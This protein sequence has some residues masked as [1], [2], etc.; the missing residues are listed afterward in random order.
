MSTHR[1]EVVEVKVLPHPNADA[2]VIVQPFG[3]TVCVRKAEWKDGDLGAYIPPDSVVDSTRPEFAFLAG[4]ERIKVRKLRGIVSQGLLVKAPPGAKIGDDVMEA[5]GVTHY[6]PPVSTNTSGE[7]EAPPPGHRPVYDVENWRRYGHLLV[8]GEDVWVTEKIHG[9]NARFCWAQGRLYAGSRTEWKRPDSTLL[10]WKVAEQHAWLEALCRAQEP[11]TLYGEAYG[12]VQDL[13]YD[14]AP[15]RYSLRI[16]DA[17]TGSEWMER[18][19][20]VDLVE[21][22]GGAMVPLLARGPYDPAA[23]EALAEGPSTIASHLR[24][25]C[26]V[27]PVVERTDP[28]IGRVQLKIVGNGYLERA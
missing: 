12:K 21:R 13:A 23:V 1:V 28:E 2:L 11:L 25:G 26:V 14:H 9:A 20:L 15:G 16:F 6:E 22:H 27:R 18:G 7:S 19:A 10:W 17:W 8:P 3:F 24:E 4:H 5:L